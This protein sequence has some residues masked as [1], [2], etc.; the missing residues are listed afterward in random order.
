MTRRRLFVP[1]EL[2]AAYTWGGGIAANEAN[3]RHAV[4]ACHAADSAK[5]RMKLAAIGFARAAGVEPHLENWP[6]LERALPFGSLAPSC[7]GSTVPTRCRTRPTGSPPKRPH[8]G[9]SLTTT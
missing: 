2:Q 3:Q 7:F 4:A 1:L 8:S 5:T 6:D 9:P